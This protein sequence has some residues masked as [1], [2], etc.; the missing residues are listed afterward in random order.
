M[1]ARLVERR[2]LAIDSPPSGNELRFLFREL[3]TPDL[4][5][6]A[7]ERYSDVASQFA[8]QRP[9]VSAAVSGDRAGI[10][11]ALKTEEED[12][13][14]RDRLYWDPLKRELEQFRHE[15]RAQS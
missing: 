2:Y 7:A 12:A 5:L 4:L 6:E 8:A 3:R 1:V 14:N 13:R 9:A 15:R 10:V 11:S